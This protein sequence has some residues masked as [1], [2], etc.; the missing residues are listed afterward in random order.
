MFRTEKST[1]GL[2]QELIV[3]KMQLHADNKIRIVIRAKSSAYEE[4]L[5][6]HVIRNK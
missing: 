2:K 5:T 3:G 6:L 4:N 1:V